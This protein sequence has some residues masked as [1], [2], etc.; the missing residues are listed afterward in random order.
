MAGPRF[1]AGAASSF[2]GGRADCEYLLVSVDMLTEDLAETVPH[3]RTLASQ[4]E[5][6]EGS[7]E[8]IDQ[9]DEGR[10]CPHCKPIWALVE[11]FTPRPALVEPAVTEEVDDDIFF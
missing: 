4:C 5:A 7:G 10:P 2:G 9:D 1:T 11:R 6:C 3:L 8:L